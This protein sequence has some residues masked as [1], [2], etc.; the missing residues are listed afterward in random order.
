MRIILLFLVYRISADASGKRV[1]SLTLTGDCHAVKFVNVPHPCP[2]KVLQGKYDR[3]GVSSG[4]F[5]GTEIP[6]Y[7]RKSNH[8]NQTQESNATLDIIR[9]SKDSDQW[10]ITSRVS[11]SSKKKLLA[12][13]GLAN[14]SSWHVINAERTAVHP[15]QMVIYTE[16]T[17]VC[18]DEGALEA[19]EEDV[20]DDVHLLVAFWNDHKPLLVPLLAGFGSALFSSLC[21]LYLCRRRKKHTGTLS[22]LQ[23][24]H[25]ARGIHETPRTSNTF[26]SDDVPV[27]PAQSAQ[28]HQPAQEQQKQV[29]P[30]RDPNDPSW[31]ISPAL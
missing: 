13:V 8:N 6:F 7:A 11:T 24:Q 22:T 10:Q 5:S 1:K 23:N 18:A 9:Y 31:Q 12:Y 14:S 4:K 17:L 21:T 26:M 25:G 16:L 30:S 3:A 28:K 15:A 29:S 19:F 2:N 20:A 27:S